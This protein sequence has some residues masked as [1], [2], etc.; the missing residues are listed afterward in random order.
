MAAPE[1]DKELAKSLAV[2]KKKPRNFVIVA[3][4]LNVLKLLID[5]KPIKESAVQAAKKETGGNV[6]TRGVVSGNGAEFVFRVAE[7]TKVNPLKLKDFIAVV[8]DMAVK[9]RFEVAPNLAEV[10]DETPDDE[11]PGVAPPKAP[12]TESESSQF[13][14]RLKAL[15]PALDALFASGLPLGEQCRKL[16]GESALL[17][18]KPDFA[19]ALNVLGQLEELVR[20]GGKSTGT[21]GEG[22]IP[23]APPDRPKSGADQTTAFS[24]RLKELMPRIAAAAETD[25]G[26]AAKVKAAEAGVMAR[27]QDFVQANALLDEVAR[28]LAGPTEPTRGK[29]D[30][31]AVWRKAKDEADEQLSG[32]AAKLRQAKHPFLRRVADLGLQGLASDPGRVFVSLQASLFDYQS[33]NGEARRKSGERILAAVQNYRTFVESNRLIKVFE[34]DSRFGPLAISTKL[35]G[36]LDAIEREVRS[37]GS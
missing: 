27:K 5:K 3:K 21:T 31:L 33:T 23:G 28:I 12:P 1:Q 6:V 32:L 35:L 9:P 24:A 34:K 13:A 25:S 18:R 14:Q 10:D 36:A 4:G 30:V 17:A 19:A 8:A 26:K 7:E 20:E 29:L 15:K 37:G 16:A 2:A 11:A 22:T